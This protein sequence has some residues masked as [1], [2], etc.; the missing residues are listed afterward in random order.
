MRT[1]TLYSVVIYASGS[2]GLSVASYLTT[3]GTSVTVPP[4]VLTAGTR[5][6]AVVEALIEAY[7]PAAPYQGQ[8]TVAS[9]DALTGLFT[10]RCG[11]E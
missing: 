5:Y 1:P 6:A 3:T 4:G 8:G 11:C 2:N 7:D 10:P 9:A